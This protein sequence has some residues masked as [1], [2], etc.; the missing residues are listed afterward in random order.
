MS[1]LFKIL[2][3]LFNI[4]VFG[5][6]V[7]GF[8]ILY[9]PRLYNILYKVQ[10]RRNY[11]LILIL[12]FGTIVFFGFGTAYLFNRFMGIAFEDNFRMLRILGDNGEKVIIPFGLIYAVCYLLLLSELEKY[13]VLKR[14]NEFEKE[15]SIRERE[16]ENTTDL[17]RQRIVYG[18]E[19]KYEKYKKKFN[20]IQPIHSEKWGRFMS[21]EDFKDYQIIHYLRYNNQVY[22][23]VLENMISPNIVI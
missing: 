22:K 9:Y 23:K 2:I 21:Y 6:P 13:Y 10:N 4:W 7:F 5:S 8:C 15:L 19:A 1:I 18:N 16:I 3:I 12:A 20:I 11:A 17:E 14:G